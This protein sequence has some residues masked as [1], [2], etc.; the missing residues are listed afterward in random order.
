MRCLCRPDRACFFFFCHFLAFPANH[1]PSGGDVVFLTPGGLP[2]SSDSLTTGSHAPNGAG[3]PSCWCR[4]PSLAPKTAHRVAHGLFSLTLCLFYFSPTGKSWA[5]LPPVLRYPVR[6]RPQPPHTAPTGPVWGCVGVVPLPGSQ[7]RT[8][9]L[10]GASL[11]FTIVSLC[12]SFAAILP[13]GV[14]GDS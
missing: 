11:V 14:P 6:I 5:D 9:A 1:S 13:A 8:Q 4:S 7:N 2:L 10:T 3:N 12:T